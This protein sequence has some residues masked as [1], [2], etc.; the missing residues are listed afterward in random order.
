MKKELNLKENIYDICST[1]YRLCKINLEFVSNDLDNSFQLIQFKTPRPLIEPIH[2]T[3]VNIHNNLKDKNQIKVIYHTDNFEL[4]FLAIG[5][6]S[7]NK[8]IGTIILGPFLSTVP[9]DN[10]ISKIIEGNNLPLSS[11]LQLQP[12]YNTIPILTI[13]DT[14]SMGL[15]LFN[16]ISNKFNQCE[17]TYSHDDYNH[18]SKYQYNAEFENSTSETELRYKLEKN[19]LNA[20]EKG[21]KDEALKYESS[22]HF[23]PIHRF[24][25]NPLRAYKDLA[26]SFNTLLRIACE[27]GGVSPIYI[28]GLSDR[29]A[30][31]IENSSTMS[32]LHSLSTNMI[33]E[34]C[35]LVNKYST[36]GYSSIIKKAIDYINFHYK[37]KLS[38]SIIA[39]DIKINPSHLSRQFKKE[40]NTTVTQFINNKRIDEAKFLIKQ[41]IN[42]ITEIAFMVGFESHNYFCTVFKNV[43]NKTPLE[44]FR[45]N[46]IFE[47]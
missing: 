40:T 3:L 14:N 35:D 15:L 1:I 46:S 26:F 32:E 12:Y 2:K 36:S 44:Y 39:K 43:T 19:I 5:F 9:S 31:L 7:E 41:N 38:L 17:I 34:Y 24:P 23:K 30:S 13:D 42:S 21:L 18:N 27:R 22:F 8:Y 10:L 6:F 25:Q 28:Q 4:S 11:K 16:F 20:V 47:K 29:F 45:E 37:D 33:C